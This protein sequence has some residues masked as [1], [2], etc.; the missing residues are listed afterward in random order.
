MSTPPNLPV[1]RSRLLMVALVALLL[2]SALF[3]RTDPLDSTHPRYS[4]PGDW[5]KYVYMAEHNPFDFHIAPYAWRVGEPALVKVLPGSTP[6]GFALITFLSIWLNGVLI[7]L[8]ARAFGFARTAAWLGVALYFSV[9]WATKMM[10]YYCQL[11][12]PFSL[13]FITAAILA[14]KLKRPLWFMI[15]AALGV[16]VKESVIFVLPLYYSLN[17]DHWFNSRLLVRTFLLAVPAVVVYA[18]IRLLIPQLGDDPAYVSDLPEN[19]LMIQ[20]GLGANYNLWAWGKENIAKR[21]AELSGDQLHA[22]T[23]G[24][25]GICAFVLPLFALRRNLGLLVRFSPFLLLAY[26]QLA[27]AADTARLVMI[28]FPAVIV[29]AL[30]GAE[31]IA[32]RLRCP[33]AALIP[34]PLIFFT[35][36]LLQT[37][38][39]HAPAESLIVVLYLAGLFAFS[40]LQSEA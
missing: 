23:I 1:A 38:T 8:L 32:E 36:L 7:Y 11:V 4:H 5:H 25:F 40:P 12:D 37:N 31:H 33:V 24:A 29:M 14:A 18:G 17:T 10:F 2:T 26:S 13:L 30:T 39:M 15:I 22:M 16:S 6:F 9:G 28:A 34:L 27:F 19:L 20:P 3:L 35:F 21:L